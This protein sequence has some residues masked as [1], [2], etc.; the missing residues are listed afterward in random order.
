M[1][2]TSTRQSYF[3]ALSDFLVKLRDPSTYWKHQA[4]YWGVMLI[5]L[6]ASGVIFAVL[7]LS[8]V[9]GG[10]NVTFSANGSPGSV[11]FRHYT[12]MWFK[13]GKYKNCKTC[14]ESIFATQH[15]GSFI[16]RALKDSPPLKVHIGKEV[17]TLFVP[18]TI[19]EDE[20]ARVDY[21]VPRA[22]ATCATGACHD[23]KESFSRFECLGCHKPK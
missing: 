17:S 16:L 7:T 12:H 1:N 4:L 19:V 20:T 11:V 23:G 15:Y 2:D 9:F 14:H 6:I 3:T 5:T 21:K 13:D 10:G 8:S 18:G 22:C